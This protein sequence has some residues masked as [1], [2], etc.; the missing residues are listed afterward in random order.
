MPW[1][2]SQRLACTGVDLEPCTGDPEFLTR[3]PKPFTLEFQ[4]KNPISKALSPKSPE[5]YVLSPKP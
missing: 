2:P 1:S 4:T 3:S 5:P